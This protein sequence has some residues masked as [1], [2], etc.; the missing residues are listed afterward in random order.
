MDVA[1]AGTPAFAAAVLTALIGAGFDI[2]LVLTQPDR[3]TGRGQKVAPPPVKQL[4]LDHR[5]R[6]LQPPRLGDGTVQ[7]DIRATRA[8][9]L[10]VAAYG[11]IVPPAILAWP[12]HGCINVHASLLPRWR[13][14]APTARALLAGDHETGVTIMQMDAGLD[15]GP[16]LDTVRV[17]IEARE[18]RGS[19]EAKLADVG[20]KALVAVLR[21]LAEGR[22]LAPT[23]QPEEGASYAVKLDKREADIDWN[24]DATAIDRQ[25]RALDPAPGA[26]TVLAKQPVKV[27]RAEPF[28][29]AVSGVAPGTVTAT[30]RRSI[31]VACGTGALRVDE[32]Q[33]A[34]GKRMPAAS[35]AAGRGVVVGM[36]FGAC[37]D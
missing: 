37:D 9:V 5:I 2:P 23:P 13:G 22:R 35:F 14:A 20:A 4:A 18:T 10:A 32:V 26:R 21:R 31:V 33:P 27:W 15:T 30:A 28:M 19:L 36:R 16:M 29:A 25:I 11:L 7:A 12:R 6:V 8:D 17:P 24:A 3:P 1:F 34:S